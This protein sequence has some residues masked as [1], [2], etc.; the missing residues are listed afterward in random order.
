M[1]ETSLIFGACG[2]LLGIGILRSLINFA[3][4]DF[5]LNNGYFVDFIFP[6]MIFPDLPDFFKKSPNAFHSHSEV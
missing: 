6:K 3:R 1:R 2:G 4:T 5:N